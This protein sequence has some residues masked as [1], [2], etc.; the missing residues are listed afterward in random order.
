MPTA[1]WPFDDVPAARDHH[2]V[3]HVFSTRWCRLGSEGAERPVAWAEA[4]GLRAVASA[5][6]G[7]ERPLAEAFRGFGHLERQYA[8]VEERMPSVVGESLRV[9]VAHREHRLAGDCFIVRLSSGHLLVCVSLGYGGSLRDLPD[10]L[11]HALELGP[12]LPTNVEGEQAALTLQECINDRIAWTREL[13]AQL[14]SEGGAAQPQ[15][16][17]SSEMHSMI[18]VRGGDRTLLRAPR[19]A[20]WLPESMVSVTRD[21]LLVRRL[22]GRLRDDADSIRDPG[23]QWPG[24]LNRGALTLGAVRPGASVLAGHEEPVYRNAFV[25]VLLLM[26]AAMLLR[27][28]RD[29]TYAVL[30]DVTERLRRDRHAGWWRGIDPLASEQ[31]R[32]AFVQIA[33]AFHVETHLD[34]RRVISDAYLMDF[35]QCLAKALAIPQSV[36]AMHGVASRLDAAVRAAG[37]RATT[38]TYYVV[39]VAVA[40]LVGGLAIVVDLMR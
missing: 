2:R 14:R 9:T 35:H 26:G 40:G 37:Q 4:Q 8:R 10:E 18:V 23:I 15:L 25:S 22:L 34:I 27:E 30:D 39:S 36:A 7:A 17:L 6:T 11:V 32:L 29:E 5:K 16:L 33:V 24:E 3:V 31:T 28:A 13:R 1:A 21:Q 20:G 12:K 38:R 19:A